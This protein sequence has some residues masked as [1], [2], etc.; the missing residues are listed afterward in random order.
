MTHYMR[1][2]VVNITQNS[3]IILISVQYTSKVRES[4]FNEMTGSPFYTNDSSRGVSTYFAG[5][6]MYVVYTMF[7][8][9]NPFA[10]SMNSTLLDVY[11][12][13]KADPTMIK[14]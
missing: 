14:N 1:S 5:L 4:A 3:S 10:Q 13:Y 11:E 9:S 7:N 2:S 12:R 8:G 6:S